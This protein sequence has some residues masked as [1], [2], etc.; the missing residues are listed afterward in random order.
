MAWTEPLFL[1]LGFSGLLLV[2][3]HIA[4]G[5]NVSL[6]VS[7]AL[8]AAAVLTRYAGIAFA[9]TGFLGIL[10]LGRESLRGRALKGLLFAAV[11]LLPAGSWGIAN[12]MVVGTATGRQLVFH[13]IQIGHA[14]Q[15]LNTLASWLLIPEGVSGY[16][17]LAVLLGLGGLGLIAS[18]RASEMLGTAEKAQASGEGGTGRAL[19]P[20]LAGFIAIY[21]LFLLI[22]LSFFDANIPFDDRILS[23]IYLAGIVLFL[24]LCGEAIRLRPGMH[25]TQFALAGLTILFALGLM[26]GTV[27]R[28]LDGYW[29]GI[30]FNSLAWH[31]SPTLASLE[32]IPGDRP[33][34]SNSPEAIYLHSG[35]AA[36]R[37][38]RVFQLSDQMPNPEYSTEMEAMGLRLAEEAGMI[39]YFHAIQ[40]RSLPSEADLEQALPLTSLVSTSDGAIYVLDPAR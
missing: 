40:G 38:P 32:E 14:T 6:L 27:G 13:P 4:N 29:N 11:A 23:P 19:V 35:R 1:C 12:L 8:I 15:A 21:G 16:L 33:V 7:A 10:A 22:S 28:I 5:T 3:V 37:V 34:F 20:L 9:A 25:V 26:S 39:V 17:K 36:L 24:F 30:G 31:D 18:R 2:A